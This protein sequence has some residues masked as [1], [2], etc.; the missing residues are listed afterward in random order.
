LVYLRAERSDGNATVGYLGNPC[1]TPNG[2]EYGTVK[3]TI[4]DFA[5][6]G[7]RGKTREVM[8]PTRY[9]E[10]DPVRR[11]DGSVVTDEREWDLR[12]TTDQ[13]IN[14]ISRDI[15][16]G[17]SA[18]AGQMD[19]LEQLVRTGY[20]APPLDSIVIDW[21]GNP[22]AGGAGVTWNG[23]PVGSSYDLVDVLSAVINRIRQRI[24][25]APMLRTQQ[26]NLGDMILLMP[27]NAAR[28]LLDFYTCWSV[29]PGQKY[30]ETNLNTYEARQ[31]RRTLDGGRFG[32]GTITIDGIPIPI[33]GYDWGLIKGPET[34][35]MYLLTGGVGNQ[36]MWYGEHLSAQAAAARY[37][38]AGYFSTDGGRILGL[39]VNDNEC[40][41][42]R[43]WMHP[44]IYTTAPWAQVRFQNVKCQQPGGWLSPDPEETSFYYMSSFAPFRAD[45]S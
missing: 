6:Y 27:T 17:N 37:G 22:M 5:R 8:K 20:P 16:V 41:Q 40:I 45:C 38:Q 15:I 2:W 14:D 28:C 23:N 1:D 33:L 39:Y 42:L 3:M 26:L 9:C 4:E 11:L 10:T 19:G 12:F 21:N 25:M 44:R 18:N 34:F 30:N 13:I 35:D 31:F 29:C 7:R 43:E 24:M 32:Y 36:R